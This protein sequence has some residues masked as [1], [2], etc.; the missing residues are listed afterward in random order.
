MNT[1]SDD[2]LNGRYRIEARLAKGGMGAVFRAFDTLRDEPCAVKEFS[3]GYLPSEDATRV[4]EDQ[5]A[6]RVRDGR[7]APSATREKA[8]TQFKLEAR[9]LAKLDHPNLPKVTDFFAVEDEYYLVMQLIEGQNLGQ[10]LELGGYRPLPQKQVME[11]MEQVMDALAYCHEQGVIHRD[12]KPENVIV[13]SSGKVYLVDFG[14]AK[15]DP[16][17]RTMFGSFT[18]GYSPPEQYSGQGRTDERS[19]IYA[20]GATMYRLLTGQ[21]PVEAFERVIG[22]D[23]P[24][25]QS[26]VSSISTEVN[27]A[28]LRAMALKPAERYQCVGELCAALVDSSEAEAALLDRYDQALAARQMGD[29]TQAKRLLREVVEQQPSCTRN[30]IRAV[31]LLRELEQPEISPVAQKRRWGWIAPLMMAVIGVAICWTAYRIWSGVQESAQETA[32]GQALA[33]AM[34]RTQATSTALAQRSLVYGPVDGR[35]THKESG[36][37]GISIASVH[38]R[39]F[40]AEAEFYNPYDSSEG[41]WDY[42]FGFRSTDHAQQYRLSVDS[43]GEWVLTLA[44]KSDGET[45]FDTIANGQAPN[46]DLSPSGSNHLRLEVNGDIAWFYVNREQVARLNISE[47]DRYGAIWIGTGIGAGHSIE[48]SKTHYQGFTIWSYAT[49]AETTATVQAVSATNTALTQKAHKVYGPPDGQLD[50][51]RT[52]SVVTHYSGVNLRNFVTEIEFWNPYDSTE[53]PWDYG[54][55]FRNTGSDNE[56]RL[57]V[58]S[59]REWILT[60]ATKKGG[61]KVEFDTV[62]KGRVENLVLADG[63]SNRLRLAVQDSAAILF[64]NDEYVVTVDVSAKD[65]YGDIWAGTGLSQGHEIEGRRTRYKGFAI[66]SL[67][68]PRAP[69]TAQAV[70]VASAHARATA[71]GKARTSATARANR[72]AT[73][74]A[75]IQATATYLAEREPSFGPTDGV[76]VHKADGFVTTRSAQVNLRD[77]VA[78]A[79]FFNPYDVSQG[80]WD[81]GFGFRDVGKNREYRLSVDSDRDWA[82]Q[83][84]SV[85]DGETQTDTVAAGTAENLDLSADGSNTLRLEV[86]GITATLLVNGEFVSAMDVSE[87]DVHGDVWI[88]TGFFAGHEIDGESMRYEGFTVWSFATRAEA[89]AT[90]EA[91]EGTIAA[92]SRNADAVFGPADGKLDH[93][94][95]GLIEISETDMDLRDFVLKVRFFNPYATTEGDWD[96]GIGFRDGEPSE[97]DRKFYLVW[98]DSAR[99]WRLSLAT[100]QGGEADYETLASGRAEDLDITAGGSNYLQLLVNDDHAI[101]FINSQYTAT[102]DVAAHN[103]SG[104]IW[105]GTGLSSGHEFEGQSTRYEDFTVWTLPQPVD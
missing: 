88:A 25:P 29:H 17:S 44:S 62:G 61:E 70:A 30:G 96:C 33:S 26:L 53:G 103:M 18:S 79:S 11:W 36:S 2:L 48:G 42:G 72:T 100:M 93:D 78:E 40:V 95:D 8:A 94:E 63:D 97:Q 60:L 66:W 43:K 86:V 101:F 24:A 71:T 38:L 39:D 68:D 15:L 16:E 82:L 55:G 99:N 23:M 12:V 80:E 83:L 3:L 41:D 47:R 6:T 56:Y 77:F 89:T 81:Y 98:V 9:L 10:I 19:D 87:M 49:Q 75:G 5:D 27:A 7:R 13:T 32:T 104:G 4:R 1:C 31:D 37:V 91:V 51:S 73:A 69:A 54:L 35:L 58:N 28:I 105:I 50:H 59:D 74:Q 14:V 21:H 20:L 64:V 34:A 85:Q 76:L 57:Y 84:H 102:L 46:V 52:G 92:A 22:K 65:V 67:P 45:S 90:V